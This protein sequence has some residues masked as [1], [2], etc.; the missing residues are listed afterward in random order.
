MVVSF[1]IIYHKNKLVTFA[2]YTCKY[3]N[4][5]QQRLILWKTNLEGKGLGASI[6]KTKVLIPRPGLDV[7]QKSG[8]IPVPCV[9]RASAQTP[10]SVEAVP[11]GSTRDAG[12]FPTF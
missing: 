3:A 9:S 10:F 5:L 7:L 12:I 8:K 11:I 1:K 6:D 2:K 4:A